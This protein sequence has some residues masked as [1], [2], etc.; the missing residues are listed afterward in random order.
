MDAIDNAH[1]RADRIDD[2][3]AQLRKQVLGHV[4]V[5]QNGRWTDDLAHVEQSLRD[6]VGGK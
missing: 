5:A 1:D 3:I 4:A 6:L 2:L